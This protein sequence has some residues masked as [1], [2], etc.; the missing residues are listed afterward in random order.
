MTSYR[1]PLQFRAITIASEMEGYCQIIE[2]YMYNSTLSFSFHFFSFDV[3][4]ETL[5][6][7]H[8]LYFHE[9]LFLVETNMFL[10]M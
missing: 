6:Y 8:G 10:H 3:E 4:T 9:C 7:D 1:I 5:V 2:V